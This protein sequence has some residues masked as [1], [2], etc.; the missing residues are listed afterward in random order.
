M[1]YREFQS[2]FNKGDIVALRREMLNCSGQTVGIFT[3]G[4][5]FRIITMYCDQYREW[6][7][8][9]GVMYPMEKV[10]QQKRT[11]IPFV[12]SL[13]DLENE[14]RI[15]TVEEHEIELIKAAD[16]EAASKHLE[17]AIAKRG[18]GPVAKPSKIKASSN[19]QVISKPVAGNRF[20]PNMKGK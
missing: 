20:I 7:K 13:C 1:A 17:A 10:E 2:K 16:L 3:A 4:H 5:Q 18:P 14:V 12:Y 6:D 15:V 11:F 19:K 9:H 8:R